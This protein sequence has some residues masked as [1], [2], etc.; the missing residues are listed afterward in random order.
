MTQG[1]GD[2]SDP[3]VSYDG[4][5]I[6]FSMRLSD[7]HNWSIWE[8]DIAQK[9]LTQISCTVASGITPDGDDVDPAYLP[10]GRIVSIGN[11]WQ[12]EVGY[13]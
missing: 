3:E 9:S 11:I 7:Y 8:Y 10:D 1:V 2:V 13:Q 6:L 4:S 12:G 5:K